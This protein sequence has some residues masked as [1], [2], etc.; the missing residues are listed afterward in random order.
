[1]K[2]NLNL[3]ELREKEFN[4]RFGRIAGEDVVLVYP[5]GFPKFEK[6]TLVFRS[7]VWTLDGTLISAGFKKFVNLG[8]APDLIRDPTDKDL[9]TAKIM[10]KLDGS[11]LTTTKYKGEMIARTRGTLD[12]SVLENGHEIALFKEMYPAVF[13]NRWI[14]DNEYS[15]IYEWLSTEN[16]IVIRYPDCPNIKL[17]GAIRHSDYVYLKQN[18]LDEIAKEL[19]VGRPRYYAF[20]TMED[21]VKAVEVLSGEEGFCVY[22]NNEQDIKKVKSPWYLALHR[23]KSN[24][25]LEYVLDLYIQQDEPHYND[26]ANHIGEVF[27]HECL[28]MALPFASTVCDAGRQVNDIVAGM[29]R[30]VEKIKALPTRKEQALAIMQSYGKES[31]RSGFVFQLLDGRQLDKEARKKL[32]WQCLKK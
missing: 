11:L 5:E 8:E 29:E 4:L 13:D 20:A 24:C 18:E 6:H 23:F 21:M 25:S 30:F 32:Y 31:N 28:N 2:I 1:M 17:I 3:D 14:N 16:Q 22:F 7:S 12:A 27:D 19:G 9:N 15:L 10:E 26:F